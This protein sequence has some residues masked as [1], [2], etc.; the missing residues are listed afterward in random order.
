MTPTSAPSVTYPGPEGSHTGDAAAALFPS[1][2]LRPLPSFGGVARAV[3]GA[4]ADYGVLPIESSLAGAVAETHDLLYE[5]ELS[6]VAE[7]VQPVRHC[8]AAVERVPLE[9]IRTV[10]SHPS[11]F[12]Q[13][14]RA[15]G[16]VSLVPAATTADA[17]RLVAERRDATEAALASPAAAKSYGLTVL[18]GDVSDHAAFTRFVSIAAHSVVEVEDARLALS[19]VTDH[20]PG[21]LHRAIAPFAA[22]GLDL[23]RLVSRPLPQTPFRYRFDAV[24]AGHPRDAAVHAALALVRRETRELRLLGV[25][26]ACELRS[27]GA[28]AP[29]A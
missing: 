7:T 14:R 10:R 1:G 17:A 16:D 13:C 5:H 28:R 6:I 25:Y 22:A 15:L 26:P 4:E 12:D 2:E 23:E 27:A 18:V 11:A 3:A 20:R 29:S 24:V 8:L 21:A 9:R 19:F